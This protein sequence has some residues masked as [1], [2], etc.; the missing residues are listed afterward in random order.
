MRADAKRRSDV[1]KR[2]HRLDRQVGKT[3]AI[4]AGVKFSSP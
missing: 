4:V 3:D 1:T 2:V